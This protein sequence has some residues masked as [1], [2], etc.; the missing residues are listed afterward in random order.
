MIQGTGRH[1]IDGIE[2][3]RDQVQ[4]KG[5]QHT[6]V[7]GQPQRDVAGTTR[8]STDQDVVGEARVET[9]KIE[10]DSNIACGT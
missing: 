1:P 10:R 4:P 3:E 9:H 6:T 5:L 7:T 8:A 2:R